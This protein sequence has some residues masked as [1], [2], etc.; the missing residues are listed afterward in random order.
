ME[1]IA[2]QVSIA[3]E[4]ARLFDNLKRA[5]EKLKEAQAQLVQSEKLKAL[6][7]M[8]SGVAHDFNNV[9]GAILGRAQLMQTKTENPDLLR[10]LKFIELAATDGA[11]TVRRV[12]DFT[13]T[14]TERNFQSVDINQLIESSLDMTR[15]KWKNELVERGVVV[16]VETD[17]KKPS[18]PLKGNASELKEVFTNLIINALEAMPKG[19][20]LRISTSQDEHLGII[21]VSDTGTGMPEEVQSKIFDPF[22][23]TKGS[24]GTGLG[25]S[26]AYGIIT[27]HNGTIVVRSEPQEGS[28]FTIKL[29][30]VKETCESE[31]PEVVADIANA[32][33]KIL[34]ID[35][36]APILQ[37]ISEILEEKG[38]KTV[39]AHSGSEGIQ[40]AQQE[41]FDIVVTDLVMPDLSGW[42]V[43]QAIKKNRAK[44]VVILATGWGTQLDRDRLFR[45]DIDLLLPKPSKL[46]DVLR[47]VKEALI[48]KMKR[49]ET[50]R[51]AFSQ[52]PSPP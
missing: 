3:L 45:S 1:L 17:L 4:N 32:T 28:T 30:K 47:V 31:E 49:G 8:A 16:E 7:E 40:R 21:E 50:E 37:L 14:R 13:R 20:H 35:D 23:T 27:R 44:T 29:P 22:F 39:C 52:T 10:S 9:L 25:L 38:H 18:P 46:D 2:S 24:Q 33:A 11:Q 6:G 41:E 12:Q 26:V 34:L 48:L 43:A 19:G 42:Q 36:E 51:A 5:Y 15:H